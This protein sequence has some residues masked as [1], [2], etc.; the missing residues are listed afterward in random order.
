MT[1]DVI[2]DVSKQNDVRKITLSL[3]IPIYIENAFGTETS[4]L[5]SKGGLNF[6]RTL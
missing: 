3:M 6:G 5:N 4:G 2:F 1:H